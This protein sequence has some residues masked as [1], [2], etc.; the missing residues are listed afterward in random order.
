MTIEAAPVQLAE[1]AN[2]LPQYITSATFRKLLAMPDRTFRRARAAGR[3]PRPDLR[4]GSSLRWRVST[5]RK[6]LEEHEA[7]EKKNRRNT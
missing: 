7:A 1:S 6:F 4:L 3:I 5:V 2:A